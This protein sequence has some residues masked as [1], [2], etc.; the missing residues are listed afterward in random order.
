[1]E[2]QLDDR[3]YH[4]RAGTTDAELLF[5]LAHQFGLDQD[6]RGALETTIGFV[7]L[8]RHGWESTS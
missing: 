7:K 6:P 4:H 3:L 5:L 8:R 2:M 1:M